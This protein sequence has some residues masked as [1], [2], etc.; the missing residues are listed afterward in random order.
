M[1]D[2][3]VAQIERR[4]TELQ[5]QMVDPAVIHDRERYAE[6]GREYR[7][8]EPAHQLAVEYR[9]ASAAGS[10]TVWTGGIQ[11]VHAEMSASASGPMASDCHAGL[12]DGDQS[13]IG[14]APSRQRTLVFGTRQ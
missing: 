3:L 7:R 12:L 6:V 5:E 11:K 2:D 1:I 9:R 4:F 10:Q 8:L 14:V 13:Q